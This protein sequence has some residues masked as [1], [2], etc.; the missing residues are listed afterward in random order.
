MPTQTGN[1]H[2]KLITK[3]LAIN[4]TPKGPRVRLF[5]N[6]LGGLGF[7]VDTKMRKEKLPAGGFRLTPD[8]F[9]TLSVHKR[10][11]LRG[12][13]EAHPFRSELYTE[14]TDA[15]FLASTLGCSPERLHITMKPGEL[16]FRPVTPLSF[17][18]LKRLRGT[19]TLPMYSVLSSGVCAAA[20][21]QSGFLPKALCEWRPPEA[22]D[23]GKES[24]EPGSIPRSEWITE[25]GAT[26]AAANVPF[27]SIFNE[28]IFRITSET[29]KEAGLGDGKPLAIIAG[30][31]Q[32]D[33]FSSLKSKKELDA[34]AGQPG[35][36]ELFVPLLDQIRMTEPAVVFIENVPGFFNHPCGHV[37]QAVLRRMGYHVETAILNSAEFGSHTRRVR[38]FL[39]ASIW[40]GFQFPFPSGEAQETLRDYLGNTVDTCRAIPSDMPAR[41]IG[42]GRQNFHSLDGKT[43]G[44]FTKSQSRTD[45]RVFFVDGP[46]PKIE[47]QTTSSYQEAKAAGKRIQSQLEGIK[48]LDPSVA[49]AKKI[50]RIPDGFDLGHLPPEIQMEIIGQS[51]DFELVRRIATNLHQH[52]QDN[53]KK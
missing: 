18:I 41:A 26:T 5:S 30:S 12:G 44:T 9:G 36:L 35:D 3:N 14:I 40:P 11:Y 49:T 10:R 21:H 7:P 28:D 2:P 37:F 20:F 29:L 4:Q 48:F 43:C 13:T 1:A 46:L 22:R 42:K 6:F 53:I 23:M 50:H 32:C 19:K 27:H 15:G 38:G 52:L 16:L 51:I 33:S 39:V 24:H 45:D 17:Q 8:L 31:L 25:T 47:K 34:K